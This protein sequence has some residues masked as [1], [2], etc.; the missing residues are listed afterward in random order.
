LYFS[1]NH[2]PNYA[3][4]ELKAVQFINDM[5]NNSLLFMQALSFHLFFTIIEL[6]QLR[7]FLFEEI[8]LMIRL[9]SIK[10]FSQN[11]EMIVGYF[12]GRINNS[13]SLSGLFVM[14]TRA[15]N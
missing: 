9:N 2:N 7:L 5:P 11:F 12:H 4:I 10:L 13:F 1:S 8:I 15:S 14:W 6:V 3:V